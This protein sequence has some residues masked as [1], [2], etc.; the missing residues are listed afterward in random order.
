MHT[1]A[2]LLFLVGA[3]ATEVALHSEVTPVQKVIQLMEGMLAK[4]KDEKHKE[5]T[6]YAA[7]K[8]W[9]DD[10]SAAKAASIAEATE[11]VAILKADI[12]KATVTAA[13][14]TKQIA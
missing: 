10:T 12:A 11:Q 1:M 13:D 6:Q 7:Y 3:G 14:L 9:C 2:V 4:G 8:Q 5:M